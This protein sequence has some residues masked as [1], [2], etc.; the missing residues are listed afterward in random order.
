MSEDA[1]QSPLQK[2]LRKPLVLLAGFRK[3]WK[4][5]KAITTGVPLYD[6]TPFQRNKEGF[7]GP[8]SFNIQVLFLRRFRQSSSLRLSTSCLASRRYRPRDSVHSIGERRFS[9]R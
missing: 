9:R 5:K 4:T 2:S 1:D 8:W 3:F 6:W 7:L